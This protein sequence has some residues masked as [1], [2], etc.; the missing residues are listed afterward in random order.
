M[1][2]SNLDGY[3][4]T[5]QLCAQI[6][7]T[8][9][10][11]VKEDPSKLYYKG[12][13]LQYALER[14]WYVKHINNN[15]LLEYFSKSLLEVEVKAINKPSG[16]QQFIHSLLTLKNSL[17]HVKLY[18]SKGKP[19]IIFFVPSK[20]FVRFLLPVVNRLGPSYAFLSFNQLTDRFLEGNSL[21]H[22]KSLKSRHFSL[23]QDGD[24]L[25]QLGLKTWYDSFERILR[26]FHPRVLV[27]VEGN[28]PADEVANQVAKKLGITVICLQQGWSPIIHSGFRNMNF[29][30]ML[31]WGKGFANLLKDA[32][33][34]QK[35]ILAG[36]HVVTKTLLRSK[37][38]KT[39]N[40]I[41]FPQAA[42]T[43]LSSENFTIFL[44]LIVW[45]ALTFPNIDIY[46]R[47]HP[48]L[49]LTSRQRDKLL[50][51]QNIVFLPF[52]EYSLGEALIKSAIS[53]SVYSSTILE[54][55]AGGVVPIIF[56]LTSMPKY[57]PD[58]SAADAGI[59]VKSSKAAKIAI[60]KLLQDE[61]FYRGFAKGMFNF[62][63]LYFSA[64]GDQAIK[65][66]IKELC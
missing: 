22:I 39:K 29:S 28:A 18:G 21:P 40:V 30:K 50:K 55:I 16:P 38:N 65:N 19:E 48:N 58:V 26:K 31:V 7:K 44:S 41:F 59:E 60:R 10:K 25:E 66:I 11:I 62:R 23:R 1:T 13:N 36:N 51:I 64:L 5:L 37:I 54:S 35:F 9:S 6:E 4:F 27:V 34:H 15:K 24:I 20:K 52:G 49:P 3:H 43:I 42:T 2:K 32:N 14:S 63:R 12:S 8:T 57:S 17:R 61:N 56:N 47:E 46:V 45:T 33:P 53:I